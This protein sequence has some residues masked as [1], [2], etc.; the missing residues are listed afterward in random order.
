MTAPVYEEAPVVDNTPST[1]R[2]HLVKVLRSQILGGKY[3][4][5]DRL[6]ESQIA[7]EFNISRIPVREALS[8]LQ[9][10]GLVMN[11]ERRGMFVVQLS[12]DEVQQINSLRMVLEAEAMRLARARMTPDVLAELTALVE[13]MEAWE[14]PLLDA[15]AL[16]RK[17]HAVIWQASGNPYLERT[18]V[19]L[20]TSLFAHKALE[21]VS[22]EIRRWRLNHHRELLDY[23]SGGP[24]DPQMAMLTHLRMAYTEPERFSSLAVSGALGGLES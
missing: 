23:V 9:E 20:T 1:L 12:N 2:T 16:D 4:P 19:L 6:N 3:R 8:Q 22:S 7:R 14:G 17:F 24:G 21:H 15:A 18:L 13:Q 5:G 11:H 10:Q